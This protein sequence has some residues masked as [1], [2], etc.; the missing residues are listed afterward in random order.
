MTPLEELD[1]ILS[2]MRKYNL[3][4]SPILEYTINEKKE[5]LGYNPTP[6]E[7]SYDNL[8]ESSLIYNQQEEEEM[9]EL[10]YDIIEAA[11]TPN[12]G[13][14]KSQLAAIGISWP[15]PNDWIEQVLGK[16]IT[17]KQLSDFKRIQYVVKGETDN[18][19]RKRTVNKI[20]EKTILRVTF[21]DGHVIEEQRAKFTFVETI[22]RIGV[23]RVR[24]LGISF[25]GVPIVS[26]TLDEKY[27]N[28]QVPIENGFYIMTHSSTSTKKDLLMRMAKRLGIKLKVEIV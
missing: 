18:P 19:K 8:H 6:V 14:T 22:R 11:K 7:D 16:R 2:L 9:V 25:C 4:I 17:K 20:K 3:P 12:G 23:M 1:M 15:R 26:R 10:T 5:E 21:S 28:T 13:Y 24:N 27:G